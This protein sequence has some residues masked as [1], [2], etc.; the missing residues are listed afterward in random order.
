MAGDFNA[1]VGRE[2]E[3]K[4]S[5]RKKGGGKGSQGMRRLIRKEGKYVASWGI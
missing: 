4:E 1:R 2:G 3:E 5:M